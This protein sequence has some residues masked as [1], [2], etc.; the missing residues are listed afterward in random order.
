M[1]LSVGIV[2]LPNVGKST[3]FKALTNKQVDIAN[4]P[5]CTI[6]PN[7]GIIEVPDDRLI[8]LKQVSNSEKI[9]NTVIK[10]YDIAGLVKG[11]SKG[12]GLG[13]KFLTNIREVDAIAHVVRFLM[14]IMLLILMVISIQKMML[15]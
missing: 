1:S 15:K 6:E 10:F 8:K 11:A 5:F 13:N 14:I 7:I 4:Y 3:I 9:T 12:E 2:G